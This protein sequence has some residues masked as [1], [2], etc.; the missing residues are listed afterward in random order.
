MT[1]VTKKMQF[2]IYCDNESVIKT[3]ASPLEADADQDIFLQLQWV[4]QAIRHCLSVEFLH[5]KGHQSIDDNSSREARLN[6]WCDGEAKWC[7]RAMSGPE[8]Q[9]HLHFPAAKVTLSKDG[10]VGRAVTPWFRENLTHPDLQ[11]Y[12]QEKYRWDNS[13]MA[14]IDWSAYERAHRGLNQSQKTTMI[15]FRTHWIATRSRLFLLKQ[16]PNS[17][18]PCCQTHKETWDHVLKCPCQVGAHAELFH[19]LQKWM[20][21]KETPLKLHLLIMRSLRQALDLPSSTIP[22]LTN[23]SEALQQFQAQQTSIGWANL[24]CGFV[25]KSLAW[26][27]DDQLPP[28]LDESGNQW[29]VGFLRHLQ[30]WV[31]STWIR[32]CKL[33]HNKHREEQSATRQHLLQRIYI[34]HEQRHKVPFHF[35]KCFDT[36][37]K[38]FPKKSD[39]FLSNWLIIHEEVLHQAIAAPLKQSCMF[40]FFFW[41]ESSPS[42]YNELQ[43]LIRNMAKY[44][45]FSSVS[46]AR[47]RRCCTPPNQ[48]TI[49]WRGWRQKE[50]CFS[51]LLVFLGV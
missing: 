21:E 19:S 26:Y 4:L 40:D 8:S 18:C 14:S 16:S 43:G 45:L 12:F 42:F 44:H 35:Q 9:Q 34:L 23:A 36:P 20:R 30:K 37:V 41:V 48:L 49:V 13:S 46:G 32:R 24:F 27:M 33:E 3:M 29:V 17:V 1:N 25:L 31:T 47:A 11:K 38:L 10:S 51:R 39:N 2:T 5:V 15:K 6:H 50:F 7:A 28:D 22:S